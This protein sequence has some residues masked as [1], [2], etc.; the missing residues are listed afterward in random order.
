VAIMSE[1]A[2]AWAWRQH[3]ISSTAKLTLLALAHRHDGLTRHCQARIRELVAAT[4]LVERTI[5]DTV[6][7]LVAAGLVEVVSSSTSGRYFRLFLGRVVGQPLRV[8]APVVEPDHVRAGQVIAARLVTL[9]CD[10]WGWP[11]PKEGLVERL[12][13]RRVSESSAEEVAQVVAWAAVYPADE[14]PM[15]RAR[16]GGLCSRRGLGQ[17]RRW[18]EVVVNPRGGSSESE[19][20]PWADWDGEDSAVGAQDD[21]GGAAGAREG[22]CA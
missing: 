22:D 15:S 17:L 11:R 21:A 19:P 18:A 4:G 12:L 10:E 3:G 7:Q 2:T 8:V 1:Q 13:A 14:W 6:H 20:D 9:C 16:F 5:R